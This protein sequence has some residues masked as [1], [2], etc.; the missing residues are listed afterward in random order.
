[1]FHWRAI[2]RVSTAAAGDHA[3][4]AIAP[5]T[6]PAPQSDRVARTIAPHGAEGAPVFD[7]RGTI[8]VS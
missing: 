1:M 6:A 8:G 3:A 7:I 4:G 2:Y 5:H